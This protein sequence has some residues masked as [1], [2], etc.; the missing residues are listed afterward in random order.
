MPELRRDLV[1]N[2]WVVIATERAQRPTD[3]GSEPVE[4][5][6][7]VCVLCP[8]HE[9]LTPPEIWVARD[10]GGP[11][12]PGW[13]VRVVA[14]KFPALRVE[15]TLDPEGEGIY[16]RMNGIGAHEVIIESPDH[17]R[18]LEEHSVE[19]I[20]LVLSAYKDRTLDLHRDSR[21]RYILIFKNVGRL[22]GATLSHGHSQ[23]IATPVTPSAIK[24]KLAGA[25]DYYERKERCVFH[26]ILRQEQRDGRRVVY[27][28]GGFLVFCPFA[29]RFPFETC[30]LPK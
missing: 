16:D 1:T 27:E 22:S 29:S 14:N 21:L 3:F 9:K 23:L 2:R 25:R 19:H 4:P 20:G 15:G 30:I 24:T 26:D 7:G 11:N 17:T 8:G 13:K 18:P 10:S 12:Q 6:K 28:N 5:D